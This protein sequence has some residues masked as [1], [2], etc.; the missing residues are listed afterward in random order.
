MSGRATLIQMWTSQLLKQNRTRLDEDRRWALPCFWKHTHTPR[1]PERTFYISLKC[2]AKG[3]C[4]N[5][6]WRHLCGSKR[7]SSNQNKDISKG[8]VHILLEHRVC[9]LGGNQRPFHF[10]RWMDW[11]QEALR[12]Q[13]F[14]LLLFS[15]LV[16][17]DSS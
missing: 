16:R 14:F 11:T 1:S 6:T 9:V 10:T 15:R 17:S 2:R 13:I 4:E 3:S 7:A 12:A 5:P 8:S